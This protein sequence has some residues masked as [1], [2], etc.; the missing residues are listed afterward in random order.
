MIDETVIGE[1]KPLSRTKGRE[2]AFIIAFE[3][4]FTD[5]SVDEVIEGAELS[6]DAQLSEFALEL[7]YGLEDKADEINA[8]IEEYSKGWKLSRI[9]RVSMSLLKIAVYEMLYVKSNAH[10]ATINAVVDLAKKYAT[11]DDASFINGVL[12]GVS[13]SEKLF[14]S[15]ES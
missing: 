2:Q 8:I 10:A 7:S 5:A 3:R 4:T 13:R 15:D 1:Q 6:R 12:G 9:S 14:G 11:T